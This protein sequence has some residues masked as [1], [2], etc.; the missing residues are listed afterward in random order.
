MSDV[1]ILACRMLQRG[2]LSLHCLQCAGVLRSQYAPFPLHAVLLLQCARTVERICTSLIA[3]SLVA[4]CCLSCTL[5][6]CIDTVY[7][8]AGVNVR[9]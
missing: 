9:W 1:F 3:V 4:A 8:R 7:V 5:Q 6:L 2:E